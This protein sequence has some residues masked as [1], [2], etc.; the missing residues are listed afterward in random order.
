MTKANIII[1][2]NKYSGSFEREMCAYA[3]GLVDESG[4]GSEGE[5]IQHFVWWDENADF[6]QLVEI[7]P[8]PGYIDN[9][10]GK[11]YLDTSENRIVAAAE[12]VVS[13]EK[14]HASRI[15]ALRYKIEAKHFDQTH[16]E[17]SCN[18]E[19]EMILRNIENEKNNP[20]FYQAYQ[21]V[22]IR[23]NT[24]PPKEVLDEMI[25]RVKMFCQKNDLKLIGIDI[26]ITTEQIRKNKLYP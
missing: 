8:T 14:H 18:L 16:T 21:S 23:V 11:Q 3:T 9:G 13:L 4:V 20:S 15:S 17:E 22:S 2:T 1:H 25:E 24:I 10:M 5:N 26:E 19:I 6:D 7:C 12:K